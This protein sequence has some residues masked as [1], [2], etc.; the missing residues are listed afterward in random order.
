MTKGA[1]L[2]SNKVID[3]NC[4]PVPE[5]RCSN[6]KHRSIGLG[7]QG[8]ADVFL[9]LRLPFENVASQTLNEDIFDTLYCAACEAA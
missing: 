9:M 3:K 5:A 4:Y 1:T 8:L 6:T 7:V 2:K